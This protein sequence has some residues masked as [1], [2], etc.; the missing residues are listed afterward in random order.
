[1]RQLILISFLVSAN[2]VAQQS[3]AT[4]KGALHQPDKAWQAY[5]ETQL[6][7]AYDAIPVSEFDGDWSVGYSPRNG[8]NLF[9]QRNRAEFGV[10]KDGWRIGLEYRQEGTLESNRDTLEF[11]RLYQQHLRP[12]RAREFTLNPQF[13]SW[14]AAGL[15]VSRTFAVDAASVN[16]PLLMVSGALY[17]N[18][19]N[20]DI[21]LNGKVSYQPT[22]VYGF[23]AQY[24]ESDTRYT[25]PF[26]KNQSQTSSGAS[27]SLALQWPLSEHLKANLALNDIWSRMRWSNLP[28]FEMPINSDVISYD[29]DGNIVIKRPDYYGQNSQINKTGT[30]GASGALSLTYQLDQWTMKAGMDRIAGTTI[31]AVALTYQTS[32]GAFTTSYETRFNTLGVGYDYGPFRL[33]LRSNRWPLDEASAIGLDA[34]VHYTF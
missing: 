11:Y 27:V 28:A 2:A 4:D 10:E 21:D 18:P 1:M 12:D 30:I 22:D 17:A 29:K 32:W 24:R 26:M 23:N 13:R 9:L 31:P 14:S 25:Y 8:R 15:R 3:V 7:A 16:G 6:W 33:H 34:G 20:R 5:A 19:R